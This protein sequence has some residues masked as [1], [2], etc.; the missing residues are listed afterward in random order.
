MAVVALGTQRLPRPPITPL[1]TFMLDLSSGAVVAAMVSNAGGVGRAALVVPPTP[2]LRGLQVY[3]QGVELALPSGNFHF[4]N[5]L[6][7][8]VE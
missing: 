8:R 7:A 1:G 4:T 3:A 6:A 5:R 2:A